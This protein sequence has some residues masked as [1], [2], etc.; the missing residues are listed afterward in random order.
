[1]PSI[2]PAK[3]VEPAAKPAPARVPPAAKTAKSASS[4]KVPVAL[5]IIGGGV[6]LALVAAAGLWYVYGRGGH[7]DPALKAPVAAAVGSVADTRAVL[8]SSL[9]S[10]GCTWLDVADVSQRGNGIVAALRGVA[11]NPDDAKAQIGKLLAAKHQNGVTVDFQ[12]VAPIEAS[13]CGPLDALRQIRDPQGGHISV[14]TR[15]FEITKQ[16]SGAPVAKAIVNFNFGDPK[17][18]MAL[19]GVEPSG[20]ISQL[21][22]ERS[23]LVGGSEDLGNNQYR[24]SIDVSHTGWSGLLLLTGQ[25]PFEG[26]LLTGP[27]GSRTGDWS[28]RFLAA[29]RER[30]WHSEMVWFKTVDDQPD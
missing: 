24:L 3:A 6:T 2:E 29:A 9:A 11:G 20:T 16:P 15:Q 10:L 27:A 13:E 26:S 5:I 22:S 7:P 12:D 8:D 4:G 30:G 28:D 25:K 21:T 17:L 1:L 19:F 18:E 23:Q 14:P